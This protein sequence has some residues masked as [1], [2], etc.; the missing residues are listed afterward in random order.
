M[1]KKALKEYRVWKAMKARCYCPS[2]K[3]GNYKKDHI[4]VC[5]EWKNSFDSFIHDMGFMPN[6]SYSIERIDITKGYEPSNC[7]W[8]LQAEQSKNRS[9]TIW[10]EIDGERLCLRDVAKKINIK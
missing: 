7:K 1:N 5:D 4:S 9:N 6:D 8:I 3:K 2:Q 10:V